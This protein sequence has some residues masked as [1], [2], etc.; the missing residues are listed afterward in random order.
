MA[1]ISLSAPLKQAILCRNFYLGV[2]GTIAV[3]LISSIP[4]VVDSLSSDGLLS[5][6]FHD[7]LIS[8]ALVSD[9]MMLSLPILCALPFTASFVDDMK[10]GFI[11]LYLPRTTTTRYLWGKSVACALSGG[12]VLAS[13][14]VFSYGLS[15]LIFLPMEAV[16]ASVTGAEQPD[17]LSQ[18]IGNILLFFLSGAFWSMAGLLLA[19]LTNSRYMA[20]IS[21]FIMYYVL[22]ILHER[23]FDKLYVMYPKEW[24]NP[25]ELWPFGNVGVALL[26]AQLTVILGICFAVAAK[27]RLAR[28]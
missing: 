6:G 22:I 3:I 12:L 14:I 25:S 5:Y 4:A 26:L 28:V 7:D 8:D 11:K 2:A 15:A 1:K 20:Y 21:P 17:Y 27:R 16:P 9:S 19:T 10:S 23:Y 24:L 13:G 18:L